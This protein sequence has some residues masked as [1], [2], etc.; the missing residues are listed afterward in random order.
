MRG[1]SAFFKVKGQEGWA[2]A[3]GHQLVIG[4]RHARFDDFHQATAH[5]EILSVLWFKVC[6]RPIRSIVDF[7]QDIGDLVANHSAGGGIAMHE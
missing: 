1:A 6:R 2:W 7:P 3:K 5:W 4:F